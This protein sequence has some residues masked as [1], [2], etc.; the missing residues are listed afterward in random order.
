MVALVLFRV[1]VA[2]LFVSIVLIKYYHVQ[3]GVGAIIAVGVMIL[4]I[5]FRRDLNQYSRLEAHFLTNLNRREEVDRKR[6]PLKA[7]FNNQL[8][9]KDIHL[10]IV[11]VS[12]CSPYAG[13][14]LAELPLRKDFGVSIVEIIRGDYKIYIPGGSDHIYPQDKVVVVGTD[15]QLKAFQAK[16]EDQENGSACS[17]GQP[18]DVTVNSFVVDESFPFLGQSIMQSNVGRRYNCLIVALERN[19]D[20]LMTPDNDTVFE[21]DDLVWV[22]GGKG[23]IQELIK[24]E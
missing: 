5:L 15:E 23:K 7:S 2:I 8:S 22:V 12:P 24:G 17:D 14:A 20:S 6:N 1:F 3:Y 10:A 21:L 13:K 4:I 16:L 18:K 11:P 9:D 19:G